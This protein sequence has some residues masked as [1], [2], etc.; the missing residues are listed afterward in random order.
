MSCGRP[1]RVVNSL[2]RPLFRAVAEPGAEEANRRLAKPAFHAVPEPESANHL[3]SKFAFRVALVPELGIRLQLEP[4]FPV[5][6]GPEPE[7]ESHLRRVK[8][9]RQDY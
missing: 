7:V 2:T 1:F 3:P 4:A 9:I 5:E 6:M 8:D